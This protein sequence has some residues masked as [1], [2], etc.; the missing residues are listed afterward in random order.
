MPISIRRFAGRLC[1]LVLVGALAGCAGVGVPR[2]APEV[3]LIEVSQAKE[4]GGMLEQRLQIDLRVRNPNDQDL[5]INGM[6]FFLDVNGTRLARGL[7]NQTVTVPRLGEATMSVTAS[8][9]IMDVIRQL[10]ALTKTQ[11]FNYA[12][13]GNVHV[14]D[15][16]RAR[17]P[18]ETSGKL[19]DSTKP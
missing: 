12:V 19:M 1:V 7:S 15:G 10:G 18:F 11:D 16:M 4:A 9:G 13:K 6:D 14:G 17:L 2:E 8:T 3:Y 5:V